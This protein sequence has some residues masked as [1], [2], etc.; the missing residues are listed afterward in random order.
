MLFKQNGYTVSGY[1]KVAHCRSYTDQRIWTRFDSVWRPRYANPETQAVAD[2]S[3]TV[4]EKKGLENEA[5]WESLDRS[6]Y[7][8]DEVADEAYCDGEMAQL[9]IDELKEFS[10]TGEPFFLAVGFRKPHLQFNAPKKYWDL[11][12]SE[13]I[14]L[15]PVP[16]FGAGMP[17]R[18]RQGGAHEEMLQYADQR[19]LF[20]GQRD[21]AGAYPDSFARTLRHGYLACV[22][23]VDANVGKVLRVLEDEGL[24]QNTMVILVGDHGW[25]LGDLNRWGKHNTFEFATRA[26][27]VIRAPGQ[28]RVGAKT[29]ALVELMN[30]YPSVAEACGISVLGN[31]DGK[32]LVPL[33]SDPSLEWKKGVLSEYVGKGINGVRAHSRSLRTARYR[34]T[35]HRDAKHPEKLR[36]VELF[37]HRSDPYETV[38]IAPQSPEIVAEL[39]AQLE[40]LDK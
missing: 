37:D 3:R 24:D 12:D 6:S 13:K 30:I 33:L 20:G 5:L 38:N 11:Y 10:R 21:W 16:D 40:T 32:S 9:A 29:D 22:S 18:D 14:P 25:Y 34:Y 23:C 35:E 31:C 19:K 27:M 15:S 28:K 39:A 7:E 2:L 8:C 17:H 1:G 26:P 36:A 4:A